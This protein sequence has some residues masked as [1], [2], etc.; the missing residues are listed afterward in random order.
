MELEIGQKF[1]FSSFAKKTRT[2]AR[3]MY[4]E[5]DYVVKWKRKKCP[6]QI[7]CYIGFRHGFNGTMIEENRF[8][9]SSSVKLALLV[10]NDRTTATR[11]FFEDLETLE[12]VS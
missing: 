9:H 3:D 2:N 7:G 1:L 4:D 8:V 10:V 5:V 12:K 6:T 11:V